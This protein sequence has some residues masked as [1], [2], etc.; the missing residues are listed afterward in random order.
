MADSEPRAVEVI[1]LECYNTIS[2]LKITSVTKSW[3]IAVIQLDKLD[4]LFEEIFDAVQLTPENQEKMT[5][6]FDTICAIRAQQFTLITDFDQSVAVLTTLVLEVTCVPPPPKRKP[7]KVLSKDTIGNPL[8]E[9]QKKLSKP[10]YERRATTFDVNNRTKAQIILDDQIQS[11][12]KPA[13]I[14]F[15]ETYPKFEDVHATFAKIKELLE[16]RKKVL[17]KICVRPNYDHVLA[18]SKHGDIISLNVEC[19]ANA[20]AKRIYEGLNPQ[21]ALD[22]FVGKVDS[23]SDNGSAPKRLDISTF[24]H[25]K[26]S[27]KMRIIGMMTPMTHFLEEHEIE[28]DEMLEKMD[29]YEKI[30]YG[31]LI[32]SA[33]NI[34][35]LMEDVTSFGALGLIPELTNTANE[36]KSAC[37]DIVSFLPIVFT[38]AAEVV[39]GGVV[40]CWKKVSQDISQIS[41][42]ALSKLKDTEVSGIPQEINDMYTAEYAKRKLQSAGTQVLAIISH[43]VHLRP[44]DEGK[45][46]IRKSGSPKLGLD[47]SFRLETLL[48]L[49]LFSVSNSI[50]LTLQKYI[51]SVQNMGKTE[52]KLPTDAKYDSLTVVNVKG[53]V[54]AGGISGLLLEGKTRGQVEE[55][56]YP[57]LGQY[58]SKIK[59]ILDVLPEGLCEIITNKIIHNNFAECDQGELWKF[60]DLEKSSLFE[61]LKDRYKNAENSRKKETAK[62]IA[63]IYD[64]IMPAEDQLSPLLMVAQIDPLTIA[65][66]LTAI[67]FGEYSKL[68]VNDFFVENGVIQVILQRTSELSEWVCNSVLEF[69][70]DESR[71]YMKL[72]FLGILEGLL[73]L[74]DF[75]SAYGIYTGLSH[76]LMDIVKVHQPKSSAT[77]GAKTSSAQFLTEI[78]SY[79]DKE[80]KAR[81]EKKFKAFQKVDKIFSNSKNL[82]AAYKKHTIC[83]PLLSGVKEAIELAKKTNPA[84]FKTKE[85][86]TLVC[87]A[88]NREIY[89]LVVEYLKY[90]KES[91]NIAAVEPLRA[92][93]T[94][95]P[96]FDKY[97]Q[98][99]LYDYKEA[100]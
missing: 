72:Q 55:M 19:Q 88:Q 38:K 83:V 54:I 23:L 94:S 14:L 7:K 97:V 69:T 9:K 5:K 25:R 48:M 29:A 57:V 93:L 86:E 77:F 76:K 90:Q 42:L 37:I 33:A 96:Y 45:L 67:S 50:V 66:Q 59:D 22:I 91:Y 68:R 70:D 58:G 82:K 12:K 40:G 17:D 26:S 63:P 11:I 84:T 21:S 2:K 10:H 81:N 31:R 18:S 92:Y 60:L 27:T 71:T 100:I 73:S 98:S 16:E 39:S 62:K 35:S 80:E 89:D 15:L 61:G 87:Y 74:G 78:T 85:G 64:F 75:N 36:L 34:P 28:N 56:I 20:M 1:A 44:K 6:A 30:A 41:M 3:D 8:T 24:A 51:S 13:L 49:E 4:K 65:R 53:K 32:E 52:R 46:S 47:R 43:I 95:L 99:K 79:G